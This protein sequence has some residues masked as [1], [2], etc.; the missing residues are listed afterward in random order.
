MLY[1]ATG[2]GSI[3]GLLLVTIGLRRSIRKSVTH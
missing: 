1:L 2:N 3:A